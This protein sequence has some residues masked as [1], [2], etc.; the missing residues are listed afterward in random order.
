VTAP[1]W[2]READVRGLGVRRAVEALRS[3]LLREAAGQ[4][5]PL[6]K[7]YVALPGGGT[8]HALG[9]VFSETGLCGVKAWAHTEGGAT[10]LELVWD[11][12]SGRLLAAIEAFALG[13]LRTSAIA[14]VATAV[15]AAPDADELALCGT[16]RQ[17]V[18][19]V[20]AV[21]AVRP[22]ARVRVFGRDGARREAALARVRDELGLAAEGYDDVDKAV[23]GAPIV[24]LVTRAREPFLRAGALARGA[25][26]NALGAITPERR[27]FEPALL[28]RCG[29][30]AVDHVAQARQLSSELIAAFGDGPGWSRVR[31]LSEWVAACSGRPAGADLTLFKSLGT[32]IAD[33]AI[34]EEVLRRAR[35]RGFGTPLPVPEP[36]PL[37]FAPG[38][39]TE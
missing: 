24:T 34:A 7:T 28:E 33:L 10:P 16:G 32:G 25:H 2:L 19:Q 21:A 38:G 17:S 29:A 11:T 20:A 27:E 26:L 15:L 30:I 39:A 14:G 3:A 31:P 6:E 13:Q 4:A 12:R 18:A 9:A 23:A 8:L 37:R 35:E 22:L 36:R 1:L 5:A